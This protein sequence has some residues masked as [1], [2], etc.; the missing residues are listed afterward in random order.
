M[1]ILRDAR[2]AMEWA[3]R[4]RGAG[5]SIGLVPTMGALHAGHYAL[6][7]AARRECDRVVVTVFVNPTQFGPGEDLSRY[8][9][10]PEED[11]AGCREPLCLRWYVVT[12]TAT[13]DL[14]RANEVV[15]EWQ[16]LDPA[17]IESRRLALALSADVETPADG[18]TIVRIDGP[19][20][21]TPAIHV[22]TDLP[23][24]AMHGL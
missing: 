15:G 14:A 11:A 10:T 16:S 5:L 1:L 13:G 7:D 2:R 18:A 9:R 20:P 19:S 6:V 3:E 17:G 21:F 4:A 12:L 22:G 23:L 8:P 24:R